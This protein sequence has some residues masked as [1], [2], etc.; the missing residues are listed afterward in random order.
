MLARKSRILE[1]AVMT[2]KMKIAVNAGSMQRNYQQM[3]IR[4]VRKQCFD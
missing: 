1:S 4:L 3:E 2:N